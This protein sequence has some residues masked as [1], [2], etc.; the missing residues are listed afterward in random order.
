MA[1]C[2]THNKVAGSSQSGRTADTRI[3]MAGMCRMW[4]QTAAGTSRIHI[5]SYTVGTFRTRSDTDGSMRRRIRTRSIRGDR[6]VEL[7]CDERPQRSME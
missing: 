4:I 5:H 6:R 3:R 7:P 1:C 2:R